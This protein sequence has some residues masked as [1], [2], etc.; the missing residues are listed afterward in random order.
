MKRYNHFCGYDGGG[1]AEAEESPDGAFVRYDDAVAAVAAERERCA[2]AVESLD[3][4]YLRASP[5]RNALKRA[6][7]AIRAPSI[8]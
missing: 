6:A 3:D 1:P 7:K 5:C 2:K 4:D 8:P